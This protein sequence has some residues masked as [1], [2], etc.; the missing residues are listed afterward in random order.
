MS[1][2]LIVLVVFLAVFSFACSPPPEN[3]GDE[4]G[5]E[6]KLAGVEFNIQ[7]IEGGDIIFSELL[8]DNERILLVFWTT[9]CPACVNSV[10]SIKEFYSE[11]KE[12]VEIVSVNLGER[13]SDVEDFVNLHKINYRVGLDLKGETI[14][15][16]NLVG[17][18][19]YILIDSGGN[20]EYY[21]HVFR[22]MKKQFGP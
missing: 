21:G 8:E 6:G 19:T 20:I 14:R 17:V 12:Q 5:A 10:P 22:E 18:P 11:H 15:K 9:Q 2:L 16:F 3:P 7:D 1:R 4:A 13:R